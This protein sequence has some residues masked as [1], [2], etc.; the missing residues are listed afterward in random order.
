MRAHYLQ[1]VPFEGPGR[2]VPWLEAHGHETTTTRLFES[3]QL[4][5][6]QEVDFLIVMGGPMSANDT[7][8]VPWL[9][10]EKAFIRA[11]IQQGRR[12]LGICLGAQL[13]ASV[14]GAR[15]YRNPVK[16]IGWFPVQ[17]VSAGNG[18]VFRFPAVFPAF[19]WHGETFD[20]PPGAIRIARSEAC[21]NQA[22]QFGRA[23]MGLQF[24]LE[25]TAAAVGE[26]VAHGQAELRPAKFVQP[27]SAIL[28]ASSEQYR[29]MNELM[30]AV[31]SFLANSG[32]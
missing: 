7:D 1:H 30:A 23:V 20:L 4:P 17:G 12:V 24:H 14:L 26:M 5:D 22:F 31:L 6:P 13:I 3:C 10:E 18:E 11:C 8:T 16:E 2:I 15:V 28:G 29:A 25:M 21:E 19:H 9:A 32:G 27:A